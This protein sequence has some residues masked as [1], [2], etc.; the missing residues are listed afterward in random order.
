MT[1]YSILQISTLDYCNNKGTLN[2]TSIKHDL[3]DICNRR[4]WQPIVFD[5]SAVMS[6]L[7]SLDQK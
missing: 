6:A 5:V 2:N 7:F 4:G 1:I 3:F